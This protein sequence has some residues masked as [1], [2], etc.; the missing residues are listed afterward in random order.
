M[1][2]ELSNRLTHYLCI[3]ANDR[4][5]PSAF[6]FSS[7]VEL[8]FSITGSSFFSMHRNKNPWVAMTLSDWGR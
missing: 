6:W 8:M 2:Q 1:V 7:T 5:V 3:S 4:I